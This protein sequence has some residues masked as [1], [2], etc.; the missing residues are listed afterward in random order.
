MALPRLDEG[1]GLRG[2]RIRRAR[3]ALGALLRSPET[4][5]NAIELIRALD[6]GRARLGV[7]RLARSEAGRRLLREHP[8]L[9]AALS[10]RDAL[11]ALPEGSFGRAYLAHLDRHHLDPLALVRLQREADPH[12]AQRSA[13]ERWW[14]EQTALTHDLWH[15]LTGCGADR[16]GEARL[17][18]FI[19]AQQGGLANATLTLTIAVRGWRRAR[20]RW[21]KD[22]WRSWRCGRRAR[23]LTVVDYTSL[24]ARPLD[25][26][27]RELRVE[28][29]AG[30]PDDASAPPFRTRETRALS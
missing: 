13:S 30:P 23:D 4:T 18:P 1:S 26:V 7:S 21:L 17:L 22:L 29:L 27:R 28:P 6:R 8:S 11:R 10:A 16:I 15:V 19:W 12:W 5:E 14:I 9:L 3:R 24:L 20:G 25:A 2:E